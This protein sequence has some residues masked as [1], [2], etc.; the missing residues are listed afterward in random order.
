MWDSDDIQKATRAK[1]LY[2]VNPKTGQWFAA[3]STYDVAELIERVRDDIRREYQLQI[4]W[5]M[6]R[7]AALQ[8]LD[9]DARYYE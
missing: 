7:L 9:K 4:E 2:M 5:E 6:G 8:K 3:V 1:S